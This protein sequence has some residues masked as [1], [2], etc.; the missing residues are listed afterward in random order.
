MYFNNISGKTTLINWLKPKKN[1]MFQEV[2]PTVGFNVEMFTKNNIN[3]TIFDMSG[4]SNYRDLW[5]EYCK[6][7][8][9]RDYI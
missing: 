9:V 1:A 7:S 2:T 3:F 4:Q 5:I 8:D 6:N